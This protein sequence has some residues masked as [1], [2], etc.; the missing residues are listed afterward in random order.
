FRCEYNLE[1]YD[2]EKGIWKYVGSDGNNHECCFYDAANMD[3]LYDEYILDNPKKINKIRIKFWDYS[4]CST[5]IDWGHANAP[6]VDI[7]ALEA[8]PSGL[9]PDVISNN[10]NAAF[11]EINAKEGDFENLKI[12]GQPIIQNTKGENL[13]EGQD[14]YHF[15]DPGNNTTKEYIIAIQEEVPVHSIKVKWKYDENMQLYNPVS[16][17]LIV[18]EGEYTPDNAQDI[19]GKTFEECFMSGPF[20]PDDAHN[21]TYK[22]NK[23]RYIKYVKLVCTISGCA[24][25]TDWPN[26][27]PAVIQVF[28][29][30]PAGNFKNVTTD[31]ITAEN[32]NTGKLEANEIDADIGTFNDLSVGSMDDLYVKNS[33]G[34]GIRNTGNSKFRLSN[35]STDV[36]RKDIQLDC[37][38]NSTWVTSNFGCNGAWGNWL[39]KQGDIGLMWDAGDENSGFVLGADNGGWKGIKIDNNGNLNVGGHSQTVSIGG[40][41]GGSGT[42]GWGTG[43]VGFN[44]TKKDDGWHA[45]TDKGL[46]L[47]YSNIWGKMHFVSIHSDDVP[48]DRKISENLIAGN[49]IL[50]LQPSS[51]KIGTPDNNADLYVNGIIH[52]KKVKV[53]NSEWW[54]AV[55]HKD[56]ELMSLK[57]LEV[58]IQQHSHLPEIPPEEEIQENGVDLST[59]VPQLLKKIEE[60]TLYTI[61]QQKKIEKLEQTIEKMK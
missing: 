51:V 33:I 37:H 32:I 23:P 42:L 11:N 2:I 50:K 34:L 24:D 15:S 22:F 29:A 35:P 5:P 38:G 4:T 41:V 27:Q 8:Q 13:T 16:Y 55:F 28:K 30:E 19:G 9:I 43:Y 45:Q 61:E 54:D 57:D 53:A 31:N 1:V 6:F 60:L 39:V 25:V 49:T 46:S 20:V 26:L 10:Y 21:Q 59:M 58:Y 40:P 52:A 48:S 3:G 18:Y 17:R 47:I 56:Y 14:L 12:N 36:G 44:I 7:R